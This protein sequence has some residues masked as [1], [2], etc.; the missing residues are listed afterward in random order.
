M[1]G[2]ESAAFYK[3]FRERFAR[4]QEDYAHLRMQLMVEALVQA[5]EAAG[6]SE[7]TA[8]ARQLEKARVRMA[9]QGGFMRADDHQFQQPLVVG[10]MQRQGAAGVPFDAEGSG[11]GFQVLRGLTA[12]QARLPH[13]CRMVRPD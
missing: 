9:G 12:E 1:P 8:V 5:V 6:S 2:R 7:A 3:A 10:L 4:P 11:Y 13:S